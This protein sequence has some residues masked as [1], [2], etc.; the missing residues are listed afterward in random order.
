[1][2][3]IINQEQILS[4]IDDKPLM[5]VTRR[6]GTTEAT[7]A[8]ALVDLFRQLPCETMADAEMAERIIPL[9]R[10]VDAGAASVDSHVR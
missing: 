4:P 10:S 3:V 6:D 9:L 2:K 1:M 7:L 8:L 5:T